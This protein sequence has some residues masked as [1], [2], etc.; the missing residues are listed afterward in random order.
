[1]ST[2]TATFAASRKD[3]ITRRLTGA[4]IGAAVAGFLLT[5]PATDRQGVTIVGCATACTVGTYGTG[6]EA[7][8]GKAQGGLFVG[9]PERFPENTISNAGNADAGRIDA[10]TADGSEGTLT[11]TFRDGTLRG[12]ETGL[13]GDCSGIC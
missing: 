11:G 9:H 4:A 6:G 2:Y 12:R 3:L 13:F 5:G 7:S 1:M 8:E 10:T